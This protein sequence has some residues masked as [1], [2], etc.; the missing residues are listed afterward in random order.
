M[1]VITDYSLPTSDGLAANEG[2][3]TPPPPPPDF[4]YHV[5]GPWHPRRW[6]TMT[7]FP[8]SLLSSLQSHFKLT[9]LATLYRPCYRQLGLQFAVG[10]NCSTGHS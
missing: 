5:L 4:H 1:I 8:P 7:L 10:E 3:A 2:D 9:Q 6:G